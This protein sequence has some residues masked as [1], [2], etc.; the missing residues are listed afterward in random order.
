[1]VAM[2]AD[3]E[4]VMARVRELVAAN[5]DRC[6]WFL[7]PGQI[8]ASAAEALRVLDDLQKHGDR[9]TFRRAGELKLWLSRNTSAASAG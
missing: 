1:M 4:T 5:Q 3:V 8:P 2:E 6:L 9:D 7:R